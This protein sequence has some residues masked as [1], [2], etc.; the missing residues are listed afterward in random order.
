MLVVADL[1]EAHGYAVMSELEA[2]VGEGWQASPGSIYPALLGL[3]DAGW[4]TTDERDGTRVYLLTEVGG[5]AADRARTES[6]WASLSSRAASHTAPVT[7]GSVLDRFATN[8][9]SRRRHV[10]A[11][12]LA[13]I[14]QILDRALD[15]INAELND[16]PEGH[17]TDD[18]R[19]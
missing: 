19:S 17:E 14:E 3:V 1:G 16:E 13:V 9:G 4:L 5:K 6:R 8:V 12:K 7:L 15:D 10:P 18:R 11:P 2:R